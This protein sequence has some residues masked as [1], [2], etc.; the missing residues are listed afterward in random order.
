MSQECVRD[1]DRGSSSKPSTAWI[2]ITAVG[3]MLVAANLR[4]AV[5]SVSPLVTDIRESTGYS[6]GTAGLLT[7]LP[8]LF[9]GLAAP[10][11]PGLAARFGFERT[12]FASMAVLIAGILL[13]WIPG[14]GWLFVGSAA[15]GAGIGVC[16]VILP[17]LIKRDFT[18]SSGLMTGLYSMTMTGGAA[19]A[20]AFTVPIDDRFGGD[21]RKT[22]ATWAILAVIA[23]VVWVP[24]LR[25]VHAGAYTRPAPLWRNKIAWAITV[26]MGSQSFVFYTFVAW[27]PTYLLDRGYDK[28]AAGTVLAGGQ[29]AAIIGSLA[30]P[31][32]AGRFTDQRWAGVVAVG[33]ST[34]G[35]LGLFCTDVWAVFW[36]MLVLFG[37][38]SALGLALL[39]M[40]RR[41]RSAEQTNQ[42]S[43]MSQCLG[44]VLAAVGPFALGLVHDIT[45]SWAA[46]FAVIAV[47]LCTQ[48]WGGWL[49]GRN[50]YM[51]EN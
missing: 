48:A 49:A 4:P 34:V 5:V 13:R 44:Y 15:V 25:Q 45:G 31:I 47:A 1:A 51:T 33:S 28:T 18:H 40:V 9:F 7:T 38:G 27:V 46:A 20:A 10:F 32:I 43:G 42:V 24:Q 41:S 26:F 37:P 2:V 23:A 19:V 30:I 35:L 36:C 39:F 21:W 29:I 50:V 3:V 14:T 6:A 22:L 8:I 16:N 11:S 12:V 17:G